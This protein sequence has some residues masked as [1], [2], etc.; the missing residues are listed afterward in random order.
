M[1]YVDVNAAAYAGL[2]LGLP[3]T[4]STAADN[5]QQLLA[6]ELHTSPV[7]VTEAKRGVHDLFIT[8]SRPAFV[9]PGV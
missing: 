4:G 3:T 5:G 1:S 9:L 6:F 8:R 2:Q 7:D